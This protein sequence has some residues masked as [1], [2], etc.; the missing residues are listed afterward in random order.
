MRRRS[1]KF[2]NLLAG[3]V[4]VSVSV[5]VLAAGCQRGGGNG[6]TG[7][8]GVPVVSR[9]VMK[10]GSAVVNGVTY[11]VAGAQITNDD[12][13]GSD[14]SLQD[15]VNVKVRGRLNSDNATG[16]ADRI[17]TEIE[18]QGTITATGIDSTTLL[19]QQVFRD[20]RT[21][22]VNVNVIS[23]QAL[24]V[25]QWVKVHGMRDAQ[26][27]L[28]ASRIEVRA[29][30][31]GGPPS[32]RLKGVVAGPFTPGSPPALTFTLRG[33]TVVTTPGTLIQPAGSTINLGD[34]VEIHGFLSSGPTFTAG[35]I[36]R[37]DLE[38]AGFDPQENEKYEGE[39]FVSGFTGP[40]A[41]FTVDGVTTRLTATTRFEGGTAA[42]LVNNVRVEV[43]GSAVGGVLTADKIRFDDTVR[44]EANAAAAGS[45]DV[46]GKAVNTTG[47]TEF[48]GIGG[49]GE[50][51]L[52]QGLRIR[53]FANQDGSVTATQV[54]GLSNPL[55]ENEIAIQGVVEAFNAA[56]R[57]LVILGFTI[58]ALNAA[59]VEIDD[60]ILPA[61]QIDL[62]F[63]Q[64]TANR[65]VVKAT[66]TFNALTS[67][68]TA[69]RVEIE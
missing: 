17:E 20:S 35:R 3:L 66:G 28:L 6:V 62:F 1:M 54:I 18:T 34:P 42:G 65:S 15:G 48:D 61:G 67:T 29:V 58:D 43:E 39:G 33:I 63:S 31:A 52:D 23:C 9:G 49:L 22:C 47:L 2:N 59:D 46:L 7:P 55:A 8:S 36:D 41:D 30:G 5:L 69:I 12:S 38:D 26:E 53:G 32:D 50:I 64:L 27:R 25:G 37:E 10:K 19:G 68:L 44:I 14:L 4:A 16:T 21:V 60:Q 51:L 57:S 11:S 56:S 40:T 24:A 13:P 45:A